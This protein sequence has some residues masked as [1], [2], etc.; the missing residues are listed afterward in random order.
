M[1]EID[2]AKLTVLEN[3]LGIKALDEP[4]LY[5]RLEKIYWLGFKAGH[6]M[7]ELDKAWENSKKAWARAD[8]LYE[9]ITSL[10]EAEKDSISKKLLTD[11]IDLHYFSTNEKFEEDE[12]LVVGRDAL[13]NFIEDN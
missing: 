9:E 2:K 8:A 1:S 12:K 10:R 7:N 6:E 5:E 13:L 4:E 11:W 3:A